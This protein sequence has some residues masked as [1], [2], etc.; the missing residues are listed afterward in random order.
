MV[1]VEY[2][3]A[4]GC[5]DGTGEGDQGRLRQRKWSLEETEKGI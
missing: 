2:W 5:L 3:K 1:V 4:G